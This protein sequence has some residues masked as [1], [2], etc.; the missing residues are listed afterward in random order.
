MYCQQHSLSKGPQ[1]ARKLLTLTKRAKHNWFKDLLSTY[2]PKF[3]SV[4]PVLVPVFLFFFSFLML[5]GSRSKLSYLQHG[6]KIYDFMAYMWPV[7]VS[8]PLSITESVA[9]AGVVTATPSAG[10]DG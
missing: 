3:A 1:R 8:F 6:V 10:N 4:Y 2:V 9:E 5:K 7:G